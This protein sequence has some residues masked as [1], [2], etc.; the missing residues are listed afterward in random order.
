[1]TLVYGIYIPTFLSA[2][3]SLVTRRKVLPSSNIYLIGNVSL[4]VLATLFTG[5]EAWGLTRQA[6]IEF[7][8]AK[9]KDYNRFLQYRIKD[10]LKTTW[11]GVLNIC[12]PVMNAIADWMLIHRCYIVWN[13]NK[14]VLYPLALIAI[15]LNGLMLAAN[16][17][18]VAAY[19]LPQVSEHTVDTVSAIGSDAVIAVA[20]FQVLLAFMTGLNISSASRLSENNTTPI[21]TYVGGR[22]WWISREARKVMGRH[23]KAKYRSIVSVIVESG[24]LYASTLTIGTVLIY[25]DKFKFRSSIDFSII[26]ALM[27]GLAP[28]LI[29]ARVAQ[30][31]SVDNVEQVLST[32]HFDDRQS[33]ER[34]TDAEE[35]G[36]SQPLMVRGTE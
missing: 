2:T 8:A 5:T 19:H 23:I 21:P 28:T 6:V 31:K 7:D 9:T 13:M 15:V 12:S 25:T 27:S 26:S 17:V 1:M 10:D 14:F 22:I 20:V 18:V 16:L 34:S 30:S 24:L 3:H 36:S 29:I 11:V 33:L 4:F 35:G 32:L